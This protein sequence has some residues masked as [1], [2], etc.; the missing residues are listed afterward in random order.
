MILYD[1][2]TQDSR[3]HGRAQP[4]PAAGSP[5]PH[6]PADPRSA[7]G[8]R[9]LAA[10]A[11]PPLREG[12]VSMRQ[13]GATWSLLVL[14]APGW[15]PDPDALRSRRAGRTGAGGAEDQRGDR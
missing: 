5:T 13:G 1:D 9:W 3:R 11:A 14:V 15:S 2:N 10:G 7:S 12:G 8:H 6:R 4:A